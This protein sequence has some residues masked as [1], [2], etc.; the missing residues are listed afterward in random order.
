MA[1][2]GGWQLISVIA[3]AAATAP[4]PQSLPPKSTPLPIR[5]P[6]LSPPK[7]DRLPTSPSLPSTPPSLPWRRR[8]KAK[9]R[10]EGGREVYE[11]T[12]ARTH[13]HA[14]QGHMWGEG[15]TH[16]AKVGGGGGG[17]GSR[18]CL[19]AIAPSSRARRRHLWGEEGGTK[20]RPFLPSPSHFSC[21]PPPSPFPN[22]GGLNRTPFFLIPPPRL[23]LEFL[24]GRSVP[25]FFYLITPVRPSFW[26]GKVHI[27]VIEEIDRTNV[28]SSG[29]PWGPA[30]N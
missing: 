14:D 27:C 29:S 22:R 10:E 7:S 15:G 2:A 3:S 21:H 6:S 11:T 25:N 4:R 28:G 5:R 19:V 17:M 8:R 13:D 1:V 30:R 9:D 24:Y 26:P 18:A 16:S 20:K 12:H 23:S